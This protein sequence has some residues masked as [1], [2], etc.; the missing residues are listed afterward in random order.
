[1][2]ICSSVTIE[3]KEALEKVFKKLM[4][5]QESLIRKAVNSMDNWELGSEISNELYDYTVK[6]KAKLK[7]PWEE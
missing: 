2:S 5:Q 4:A 1:M 3:R 6:G 7:E